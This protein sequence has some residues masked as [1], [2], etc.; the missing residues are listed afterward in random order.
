MLAKDPSERLSNAAEL[1]AVLRPMTAAPRF[2]INPRT[3]RSRRAA[4][5][6]ADPTYVPTVSLAKADA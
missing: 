6:H 2:A 4:L 5:K 1:V 3:N